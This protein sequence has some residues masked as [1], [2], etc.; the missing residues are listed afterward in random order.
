MILHSPNRNRKEITEIIFFCNNFFVKWVSIFTDNS[1]ADKM[2]HI[3]RQLLK[4]AC[5]WINSDT[6]NRKT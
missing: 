1:N 2:K 3:Y 5:K 4:S 6:G